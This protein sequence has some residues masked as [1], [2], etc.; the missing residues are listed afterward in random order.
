MLNDEDCT[1]S[2]TP[3]THTHTH[4]SHRPVSHNKRKEKSKKKEESYTSVKGV[5]NVILNLSAARIVRERKKGRKTK[6]VRVL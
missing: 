3:N 1:R 2:I 5:Q 4:V 6:S